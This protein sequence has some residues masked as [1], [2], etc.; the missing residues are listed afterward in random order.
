MKL[1]DSIVNLPPQLSDTEDEKFSQKIIF[2]RLFNLKYR[3]ELEREV[4]PKNLAA[5][6]FHYARTS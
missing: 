1:K 3:A 4:Q 6:N 2:S 5:H